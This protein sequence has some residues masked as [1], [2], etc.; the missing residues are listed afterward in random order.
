MRNLTRRAALALPLAATGLPALAQGSSQPWPSRPI[1]IVVP[2]GTGGGTD[3]TTRLL[4]PKLSEILGQSVVIEN[5][6]GAGGTLGAD[7]V[8]KAQPNGETLP[9]GHRLQHGARH[10]AVQPPAL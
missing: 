6:P 2:F 4:A 10:R 9:A 8:A 5:R 3:I 7:V 1:R